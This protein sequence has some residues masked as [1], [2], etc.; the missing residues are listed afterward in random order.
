MAITVHFE[1][2][3]LVALLLD[4][5]EVPQSHTD[6]NLANTFME[7]LEVFGIKDKVSH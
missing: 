7:V 5:V 2:G 4:L 6:G 1:Q 3:A